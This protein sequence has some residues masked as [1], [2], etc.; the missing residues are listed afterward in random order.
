MKTGLAVVA[1]F[2]IGMCHAQTAQGLRKQPLVVVIGTPF[3]ADRTIQT[4]LVKLDGSPTA[5]I[6]NGHFYRDSQGR[7]RTEG[8]LDSAGVWH[9]LEISD[10]VAGFVYR[11]PGIGKARNM[12]YKV[13]LP[14]S[15]I[16]RTAS[17]LGDAEGKRPNIGV[18]TV[19]GFSAV[20]HQNVGST[21]TSETWVSPDLMTP[22]ISTRVTS[23]RAFTITLSNVL[24]AEPDSRLFQLP[25]GYTVLDRGN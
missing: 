17:Q 16:R 9:T 14:S 13:A 2:G 4:N 1:F 3:S 12:I 20:G 7:T 5:E 6:D 18:Q 24:I 22:L 11:I 8:R 25:Q 10:P 23:T 21:A 19:A 15:Q